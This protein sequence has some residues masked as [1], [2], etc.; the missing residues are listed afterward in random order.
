MS[1]SKRGV[2][3]NAKEDVVLC[4]AWVTISEDGAIGINQPGETFWG[5]IH[6]IFSAQSQIPRTRDAIESRFKIINNQC[7][8][9]KGCVRKANATPRSGSN[10]DDLNFQAKDIFM[11]DN[12]GKTFKFEHA[13]RVLHLC[14]KWY[15]QYEAPVSFSRPISSPQSHDSPTLGGSASSPSDGEPLQRPEGRDKQKAKRSG[16]AKVSK[17]DPMMAQCLQEMIEQGREQASR[18]ATHDELQ[19]KAVE[20]EITRNQ[21]DLLA[22]DL[23][24]FSPRKQMWIRQK[25]DE[26]MGYSQNSSSDVPDTP[27]EEVY[28]PHFDF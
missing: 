8:Q 20:S 2:N 24:K 18:R 25:Q 19:H 3:W 15:Q 13:W 23:S 27:A 9:W 12:N 14:P 11:N 17:L 1:S 26:I 22:A 4:N 28:R 21:F 10:L 16:K 6:E 5:R 7:S